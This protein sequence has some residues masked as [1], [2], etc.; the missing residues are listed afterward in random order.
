MDHSRLAVATEAAT[1]TGNVLK[2]HFN[3]GNNQGEMKSDH[4]LVTEADRQADHMIQEII[5]GQF[6]GEGILSEEKNTKFPDTAQTW[7]VDPLDGTVNFSSGLVYWGVSVAQLENG[8]PQH[9]AIYFPMVNELFT[10]SRGKGAFLNHKPLPIKKGSSADHM[11]LFVHCSRMLQQYTANVRYKKRSLGAAA[12]HLCLV[13]KQTAALA[14]ESTPRIWD[15]AAAWLI[16][17]E[18]GVEIRTL[19]Q[20]N[21]FPAQPGIDYAKK[22]FPILAARSPAVMGEALEGIHLKKK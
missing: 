21:P 16:L 14:L 1:R 11:P 19:G 15:F 4:T 12:Y 10:A 6:P 17:E 18:A 7:V 8:V 9:G 22:P 2:S 3:A 20:E 5:Q 13:A